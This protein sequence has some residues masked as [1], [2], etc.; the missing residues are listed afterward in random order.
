MNLK[1]IPYTELDGIRSFRD[2]EIMSFYDR[3]VSDEIADLV[4]LEG[5]VKSRED[6]L[7]IMRY[8]NNLLYAL[9]NGE[10]LCGLTWLNRFEHRSARLHFCFFGNAWGKL[11]RDLAKY[12][13]RKL[14]A[15]QDTEGNYLWDVFIG[16]IPSF[17][18]QAINFALDC[19]GVLVG[20]IPNAIWNDITKECEHGTYLYYVR[21]ED[22]NL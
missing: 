19:G 15:L 4:F 22:E 20:E 14:I 3:M 10:E 18:K 6:F 17:N 5:T 11:S 21:S 7:R 9:Y 16:L 1:I 8:G 12:A 13:L 2:S